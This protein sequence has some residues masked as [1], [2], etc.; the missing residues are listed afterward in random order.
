[1]TEARANGLA[2]FLADPPRRPEARMPR[3]SDGS[4]RAAE[5]ILAR[6]PDIT[7]PPARGREA[8]ARDMA[9]RVTK[10]DWE[11]ATLQLACAGARVAFASDFVDRAE[12]DELRAFYLRELPV[13]EPALAGAMMA[14]YQDGWAPGTVAT[15]SLA[16][17]LEGATARLP[18]RDRAAVEA[19]PE[20]LDPERAHDALGTRMDRD[21][22]AEAL[23]AVRLTRIAAPG[24]MDHAT[25]AFIGRRM[26]IMRTEED[27]RAVL[28]WLRPPGQDAPRAGLQAETV[29][30]L[31]SSWSDS[32]PP[33]AIGPALV[34]GLVDLYGDPRLTKAAPWNR[35][36]QPEM[37]AFLR[38]LTGEDLKLLF[39]AVSRAA[40]DGD[41]RRMWE[42][43]RRFWLGLYEAGRI[44]AA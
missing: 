5:R 8:L 43:R 35:I 42:D 18:G 33:S 32:E 22:P 25:V 24:L 38:W 13:A 31:L 19:L 23:R 37:D 20:L 34:R 15:K 9:E 30:A 29:M 39:D 3:I 14:A 44:D 4:R 17:A 26:R 27:V 21:G 28:S 16:R 6:W 10:N 11:G 40:R 2:A 12:F 7:A 41:E 36:A 1:M